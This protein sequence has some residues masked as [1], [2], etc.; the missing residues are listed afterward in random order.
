V[1]IYSGVQRP[2]PLSTTEAVADGITTVLLKNEMKVVQKLDISDK[3]IMFFPFGKEQIPGF[4]EIR[5]WMAPW[6]GCI[7][8]HCGIKS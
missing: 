3:Y 6:H 4:R 5:P 2:E 1:T 8:S 7:V